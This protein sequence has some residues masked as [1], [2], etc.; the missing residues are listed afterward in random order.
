MFSIVDLI[1]LFVYCFSMQVGRLEEAVLEC[2]K[3]TIVEQLDGQ[4]LGVW[5]LTE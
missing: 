2:K 1:C 5:L 4:V 3:A